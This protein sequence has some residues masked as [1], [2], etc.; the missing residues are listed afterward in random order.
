MASRP[1]PLRAAALVGLAL[2]AGILL[3]GTRL[4]LFVA[5]TEATMGNVQ[6]IFY[7]HVPLAITALL[8]P[9]VN[10]AGSVWLL[11]VH[12]RRP[13]Q[14]APADALALAGAIALRGFGFS[15]SVIWPAALCGAGILLARGRT[16]APVVAGLSLVAVGVVVFV[17]QN[18]TADG[19]DAA[20]QSS[21][22]A[23][24]LLL[25]LG[26]WAWRLAA[27]RNAERIARIRSEERAEMA[28]RVHDSVLQTLALIQRSGGD[29]ARAAA[30]ARRQEREL[31]AWL[32]DA[33]RDR[34]AGILQQIHQGRHG[35]RIGGLG[36]GMDERA[37]AG[38]N[39]V[40]QHVL[41]KR[42]H[43]RAGPS[44]DGGGVGAGDIFR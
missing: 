31:R 29:P 19:R 34:R 2:A 42:E 23:I 35:Q 24:A 20:F 7:W 17:D 26:P 14:I 27:E 44:G 1:Q 43:H 3:Y 16:G 21:A 40:P 30:L 6:R 28:A 18:A 9:Y 8:F 37:V 33:D 15:D 4:A 22:V 36:G 38:L 39:L 41:G 32:Y 12:N 11:A 5:P 25:V 13:A 10:L